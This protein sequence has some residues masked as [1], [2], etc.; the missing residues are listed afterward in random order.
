MIFK[1][2]KQV[3][4][5]EDWFLGG[6]GIG[7]LIG[8]AVLM[9]L[10]IETGMAATLPV[11]FRQMFRFRFRRWWV[12]MFLV[13]GFFA[14]LFL[15]ASP[16]TTYYG[17]KDVLDDKKKK[18]IPLS[19]DSINGMRDSMMMEIEKEYSLIGEKQDS[20]M[21]VMK[22]NNSKMLAADLKKAQQERY[23]YNILVDSGRVDL[24]EKRF[25][26]RSDVSIRRNEK[27]AGEAAME[28]ERG[29]M[30]L[31]LEG[32]KRAAKFQV[33]AWYEKEELKLQALDEK[34]Q[35]RVEELNSGFRY[36]LVGGGLVSVCMIVLITVT[37]EIYRRGGEIEVKE[38][39]WEP[40]HSRVLQA[41]T[42]FR[43]TVYFYVDR[44]LL[45]WEKML[46]DP[47]QPIS[48]NL[49]FAGVGNLFRRSGG[50]QVGG[51]VNEVGVM[52]KIL[53]TQI[54]ELVKK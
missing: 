50:S 27:V 45:T 15:V 17:S 26:A 20:V 14:M 51:V 3:V 9:A 4:G 24:M 48:F 35:A 54:I 19:R 43:K 52:L 8:L 32:E 39:V 40:G 53:K 37:R 46:P 2:L 11:W 10:I 33:A 7:L 28:V 34:R 12:F 30:V 44:I 22:K 42:L 31:E 5:G 1:K 47:D 36:I 29:K 13:N 16:L 41:T 18:F 23:R 6:I 49:N 25:E 21:E 38:L